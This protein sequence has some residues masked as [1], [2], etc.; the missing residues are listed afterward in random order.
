MAL[1]LRSIASVLSEFLKRRASQLLGVRSEE[2]VGRYSRLGLAASGIFLWFS[3]F[4][5]LYFSQ[6]PAHWLSLSLIAFGLYNLIVSLGKK[7]LL[8]RANLLA[9]SGHLSALLA[10]YLFSTRFLTVA[11]QTDGIVATY[12]GIIKTLQGQNPYLYSIKPFLDQF[13]LPPSFYTPKVDGLF[14]FHLNYPALS[15]LS[16]MPLYLAGLHDLRD[17]VLFFHILSILAVFYFTPPKFKA[18][19][20]AVFALGFPSSILYS[21][22]D[23]VWAFFLIMSALYWKR[24]R[25]VSL[26][27]FGLAGATKQIAFAALPFLLVALWHETEGSRLKGLLKGTSLILAAYLVPNL[28]FLLSSPSSWWSATVDPYLPGATPMIP[29]GIGFSGILMDLGVALPTQFF[30]LLSGVVGVASIVL[31]FLRY[32]RLRHLMWGMPALALFFYHRSFHNYLFYWVFPLMIEGLLSGSLNPGLDS[33]LRLGLLVRRPSGGA[34][35]GSFKRRTWPAVMLALVI[36]SAFAGAS[37]AYVSQFSGSTGE[38]RVNGV[39]DPDRLGVA[40]MLNVSLTNT[41]SVPISPRFFVKPSCPCLP[42]LWN[43]TAN[44][45]LAGSSQASYLVVATDANAGIPRATQFR[46]LVYDSKTGGLV[47]QSK[48]LFADIPRPSVANPGFRWWILDAS[49]GEQ[50]PYGWKLSPAGIQEPLG[51]IGPFNRTLDSGIQMRLN[52]SSSFAGPSRVAITQRLLF[53]ETKL[54]LLAYQS[55]T[56]NPPGG[57]VLGAEVNDNT[58][59]VFFLFSSIATVETVASYSENVTVTIPIRPFAWSTLFLDPQAIWKA[60]GWTEPNTVEFS[61]YLRTSFFGYYFENIKEMSR[62]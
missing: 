30:T 10:F 58:H 36:A 47:G 4:W 21:Y 34:I 45:T 24:N 9:L 33:I 53:N 8:P 60:Q 35:L 17:G 49:S 25:K 12:M 51:G 48:L 62:S 15:F 46:V 5:I 42:L 16:L 11:Y 57:A 38:V 20:I 52:Y 7:V 2:H 43:S 59:Q 1:F 22:T 23:S 37:G 41:G 19:S 61:L 39:A 13:G 44:T 14:E 3:G 40:T 31:F 26:V 28:P 29:G 27:M 6:G 18:L 32:R 50:V 55:F 56:N 54:S